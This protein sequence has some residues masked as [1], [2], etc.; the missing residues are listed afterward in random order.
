MRD[1]KNWQEYLQTN[2]N[3]TPSYIFSLHTDVK[4]VIKELLFCS[5]C[6]ASFFILQKMWFQK[7]C[8]SL[9]LSS[10]FIHDIQETCCFR[11]TESRTKGACAT[12]NGRQE[13]SFAAT[14]WE[15][16]WTSQAFLSPVWTKL[17]AS[18]R[19]FLDIIPWSSRVGINIKSYIHPNFAFSIFAWNK[20]R[21]SG[22]FL[23]RKSNFCRL[24]LANKI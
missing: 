19:V 5:S 9:T 3:H 10:M 16:E 4:K 20:I 24:F 23:V 12:L 22:T 14:K 17:N 8:S 11:N 2:E 13:C 18:K 1:I 21:Y 15:Q 6:S 7:W